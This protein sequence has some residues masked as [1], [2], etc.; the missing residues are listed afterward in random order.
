[1][2]G[3]DRARALAELE[4]GLSSKDFF[5]SFASR[6][7]RCDGRFSCPDRRQCHGAG[8]VAELLDL[9][10]LDPAAKCLNSNTEAAKPETSLLLG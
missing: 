2:A 3:G 7:L 8:E 9:P 6:D 4:N 5:L 10:F 1:M